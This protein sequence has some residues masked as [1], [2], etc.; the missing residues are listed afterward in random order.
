VEQELL[1]LQGHTGLS[2]LGG[3]GVA[4]VL[5]NLKVSEYYFMDHWLSL[6]FPLVSS[7]FFVLVTNSDH[8]TIDQPINGCKLYPTYPP[9]TK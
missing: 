4:F 1:T 3:W 9:L 5:L 8:M 7:T 2:H 6:L